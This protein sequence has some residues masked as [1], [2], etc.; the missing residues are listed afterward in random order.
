MVPAV[1]RRSAGCYGTWPITSAQASASDSRLMKFGEDG[2][3]LLNRNVVNGQEAILRLIGGLPAGTP[4]AFEAACGWSG[5][6]GAVGGL[7]VR[8]APGAAAAVQG[9]RL[10]AA[11]EPQG[12]APR[13]WRS[14][15]GRTCC[16]RRGS[17][18]CRSASW[19]LRRPDSR[20]SRLVRTAA[21]G[22]PGPARYSAAHRIHAVP[23]DF[24]YEP[25]RL[26]PGRADPGGPRLRSACPARAL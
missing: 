25:G 12:R 5:W 23:V 1:R 9:D 3:V 11:A 10:G 6:R 19:A 2:K 4:V 22:Q 8:P 16:R 7:R 24:G 17:R 21:S 18:R 26:L 20:R 14:C 15:C 13:L